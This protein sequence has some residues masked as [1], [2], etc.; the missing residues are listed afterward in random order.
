MAEQKHLDA[1]A[2]FLRRPQKILVQEN[3]VLV[4]KENGLNVQGFLSIAK[5]LTRTSNQQVLLGKTPAEQAFVD[6]WLE[7]MILNL[8]AK[9]DKYSSL[10]DLNSYLSDRVY[11]IGNCITLADLLLFFALHQ[12]MS[13]LTFQEK[14]KF[15]HLSRWYD[16]LQYQYNFRESYSLLHFQKNCL[17]GSS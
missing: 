10:Q 12:T 3:N 1:L 16:N 5:H 14:E 7:Y 4:L 2:K 17:Y 9:T 13:E 8:D 15:L 6:Q 11:M